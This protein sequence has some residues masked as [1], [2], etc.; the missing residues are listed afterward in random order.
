LVFTDQFGQTQAANG[1]PTLFTVSGNGSNFFNAIATNGEFI[2]NVTLTGVNLADIGQ[3]RLGGV[4]SFGGNVPGAVVPEPAT[5]AMMIM[6][7]GGVGA[8]MRRR[9]HATRLAFA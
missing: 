8:L 6:G 1:Q 9:R 2:T 5:W 7:F 4:G 3:V